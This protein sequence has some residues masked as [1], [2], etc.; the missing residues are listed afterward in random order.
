V[1]RITPAEA[2]SLLDGGE[3]V[4]YDTRSAGA[5]DALHA[6]GALSFPDADAARRLGAL[7]TDKSLI[8]Y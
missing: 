2:S 6:A 5:Y 8:F 4:L 1:Q 7:T 3:A